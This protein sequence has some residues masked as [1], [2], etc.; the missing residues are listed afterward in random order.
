MSAGLQI[1][2]T[3]LGVLG[4]LGTII[5]CALPL[6]RVTAFVGNNIVTAQVIWEGLWM[7]CVIQSTGQMQCKVYDSMLALP[8][9]LQAS[10]AIIVIS[11]LVALIALFASSAGGECT[12]CLESGPSKSKV[13]TTAG[14]VFVIAGI[15][16][17]IPPSWTANMV[18][19][20]FYNPLVAEAQKREL[21]AAVFICWGAG[22]L[23]VIGGGLLCTSWRRAGE[24]RAGH[25]KPASQTS[26]VRSAYV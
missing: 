15:L 26:K 18:I 13:A 16:S 23:M 7:S 1:L 9:D 10:R 12:N 20:D 14:V 25:Y 11:V 24:K 5:A 21:G 2:G 4:W 6:W 22:V 19:R 17:L 3:A 8:S